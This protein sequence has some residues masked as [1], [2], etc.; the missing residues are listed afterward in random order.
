MLIRLDVFERVGLFDDGFFLYFEETDFCRRAAD[1]GIE[2]WYVP[3]SRVAHVGSA[4]TGFQDPT[5][6]RARYWFESRR[7]YWRKHFGATYQRFADMTW[8]GSFLIWRLR[9]RIR[10][11][12]DMDPPGLLGDF[13]RFSASTWFAPLGIQETSAEVTAVTSQR[14]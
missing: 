9:R 2:T 8:I 6:P 13:V 5:R 7:R 4:S 14:G 11:L 10:G 12:P 1:A 3:E